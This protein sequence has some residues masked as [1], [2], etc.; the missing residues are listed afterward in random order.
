MGLPAC[1]SRF[2][3]PPFVAEMAGSSHSSGPG[4]SPRLK[5][6]YPE[7]V[8]GAGPLLLPYLVL[9]RMGFALPARIAADRGA[10]AL[11]PHAF[12]PYTP[13]RI[14]GGRYCFLWHFP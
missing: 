14:P 5:R 8:N 12:H 3:Y 1:I 2:L 11:T 6:S 13:E 9:L 10:H 7:V 4:I